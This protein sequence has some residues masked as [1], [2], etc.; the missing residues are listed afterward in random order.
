MTDAKAR[1]IAAVIAI[2]AIA[3]V[4][5]AAVLPADTAT[6]LAPV[7]ATARC[8]VIEL[9]GVGPVH[10]VSIDGVT[11][12]TA[13][14]TAAPWQLSVAWIDGTRVAPGAHRVVHAGVASTVIVPA[15]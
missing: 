13:R 7:A 2:V 8:G 6:P 15:C 10:D 5:A 4:V 11:V 9:S 1:L 12:M 3:A 14:D